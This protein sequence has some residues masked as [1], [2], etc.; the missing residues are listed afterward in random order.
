MEGGEIQRCSRPM[1]PQTETS[2]PLGHKIYLLHFYP[3]QL[4]A[5]LGKNEDVVKAQ[6]SD[7]N[8]RGH[9]I[10]PSCQAENAK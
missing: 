1:E 10:S 3:F 8:N 4:K 9:P 5:V 6:V 2:R 7:L